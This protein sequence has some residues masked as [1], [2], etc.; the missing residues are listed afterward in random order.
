MTIDDPRWVWMRHGEHGGVTRVAGAAREAYEALGWE[1][2]DE[3]VPPDP[4]LVQHVPAVA[5]T[6][7][8]ELSTSDDPAVA[9]ANEE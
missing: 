8:P 1:P 5:V 4:T 7:D 6:G 2:C 3:P 9:G